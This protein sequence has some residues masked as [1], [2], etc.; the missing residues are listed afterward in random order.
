MK[1]IENNDNWKNDENW[2]KIVKCRFFNK[3]YKITK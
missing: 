2:K 1:K 3:K